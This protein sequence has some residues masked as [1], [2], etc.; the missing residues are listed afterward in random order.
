MTI[1]AIAVT[2]MAPTVAATHT[3]VAKALLMAVA[4]AL[5]MA[6]VM[7]PTVV[8][9][10][11]TVVVA[12]LPMVV[13]MQLQPL[14]QLLPAAAAQRPPVVV[15]ITRATRKHSCKYQKACASRRLFLCWNQG[16]FNAETRNCKERREI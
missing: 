13:A 9:M 6:V 2:V 15:A 14:R 1:T 10:L 12:M 3:A 11:P 4:T 16:L 7:L 5:L 8:A